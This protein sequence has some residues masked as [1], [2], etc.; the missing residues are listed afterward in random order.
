VPGFDY[1]GEKEVEIG[2]A[3]SDCLALLR[4]DPAVS[5]SHKFAFDA[6]E[7]PVTIKANEAQIKQIFWNLLQ[8][9]LHAM[10]DGGEIKLELRDATVKHVK[11][12]VSDNG[13]GMSRENLE[14]IFEPFQ[15]GARGTGL[16]LSIVHKIVT[17]L[18][19]RINVE[20]ALGKGTKITLDLLK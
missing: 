2:S 1:G 14:R 9:G 18:G 10:P 8:N 19:G 5:D 15:S 6:P 3:I 17:D 13:C 12:V 11:V 7:V 16:G 20:S 4:H